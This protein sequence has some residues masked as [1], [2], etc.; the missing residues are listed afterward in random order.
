MLN[1][2]DDY[3]FYC[4]RDLDEGIDVD[5]NGEM[6]GQCAQCEAEQAVDF[7]MY[8]NAQVSRNGTVTYE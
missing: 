6:K 4:T 7:D 8:P 1:K 2:M 5:P 3:C